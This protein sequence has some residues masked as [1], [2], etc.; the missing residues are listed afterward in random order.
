[1]KKNNMLDYLSWRG[2]LEF[3]KDSFCEVDSLILSQLSYIDLTGIADA[4]FAVD[5][6]TLFDAVTEYEM[7]PE[8][9]KYLGAIIP[10]QTLPLAGIAARSA[11]FKDVLVF[12]FKNDIDEEG[13]SQFCAVSFLLP[14][15][16]V[17]VTFRGTDDTLVGWKENLNMSYLSETSAQKKAVE[18]LRDVA[19]K[20]GERSIYVC[21][22]SK[23]GNLSVYSAVMSD[24]EIKERIVCVYNN[25]GPGFSKE[26]ITSEIY[27]KISGR[28]NT[29]IPRSSIVG[30]FFEHGGRSKTVK[31]SSNTVISHDLFTWQIQGR[32]IVCEVER[33]ALREKSDR[34]INSWISSLTPE[35]RARFVDTLYA[36]L[37]ESGAKTLSDIAHNRIKTLVAFRRAMKNLDES[38]E[39]NMR[40]VLGKMINK[41]LTHDEDTDKE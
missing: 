17:V 39:E 34:A 9:K 7:L 20:T 1:M 13:E 22:H 33:G 29:F 19:M 14:T 11:R 6:K 23:G 10:K 31:S 41:N 38:S 3:N 21:G 25:D 4:D 37:S 18:Y 27:N 5:A 16:E 30:I 40:Y 24:D 12:S 32:E 15:N 8:E 26:F 35:E 2:D 28:I 36:A